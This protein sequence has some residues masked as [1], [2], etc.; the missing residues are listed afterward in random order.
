MYR[1]IIVDDNP[2]DRKGVQELIDWNGI[3]VCI[4]GAYSNGKQALD[5]ITDTNP[6]IV[7][8]DVAMPVINGIQLAQAL[9]ESYPEIKVVFMSGYNEFDFVKSAIDLDI[10]GY[11]LKP[12]AK[13]DLEC[14]LG[15]ILN[16]YM[17]EDFRQKERERM[18]RQ[19]MEFLPLVQEQFFRE[20]LFGSF[21]D[22]DDI[23]SRMKFLQ[24]NLSTYSSIC[25]MNII[26]NN[27][28]NN[29]NNKTITENINIAEKYRVPYTVKEAISMFNVNERRLFSVR[30]S[31]KEYA[32]IIFFDKSAEEAIG[33]KDAILDIA[34]GIH[35]EI[36]NKLNIYTTTIGISEATGELSEIS[37][38]YH[39]SVAAVSAEFYS[40]G[41]PIVFYSDVAKLQYNSLEGKVNME[42]LYKEV[43]QV[44]S[45][46]RERDIE[47]FLDK[48]LGHRNVLKSESYVKSLSFSII[49]ALQIA[50]I[51][52]EKSFQDIFEDE[53][54][55]KKL[56][57]FNTILDVKQWI[58]NIFKALQYTLNSKNNIR[59]GKIA[60]D[61]KKFIKSR[62]NEEITLDEIA[63][64]VYLSAKQA[65]YIFKRETGKTIFDYLIEYR[66]EMAKALLKD[67]YCKIYEIAESVGYKN[68]SHF[69][70]L[71]KK[72]TGLSP[73]EYRNKETL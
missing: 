60:E 13:E 14:V 3:G 68:K 9:K 39:Q 41:S 50:L 59:D 36:N 30:I 27:N 8:S 51:E 29:N 54:I 28:N 57:N 38:L 64:S 18:T 71:F 32:A 23:I 48:Y 46:G 21:H 58:F 15:K 33:Y 35:E 5:K 43:K 40:E 62:Y 20:I 11:V 70:L 53:L 10:Y 66:V 19:L 34:I 26:I 37:K 55:W 72:F 22:R 7:I 16:E 4:V 69:C 45:C 44:V 65:N 42:T 12:V 73:M 61:I 1:A 2:W 52:A 31:E 6:H 56:N 49:N 24:I 25:V 63:E 17:I 47:E 67:P